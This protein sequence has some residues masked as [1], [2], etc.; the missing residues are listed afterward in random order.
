MSDS[1]H[2]YTRDG[3]AAHTQPTKPGAKNA[4]RATNIK[5]AKTQKLFPSVS[6]IV[7]MKA[8]GGLKRWRDRQI[9]E[10]A[11]HTDRIGTLD[12]WCG[13]VMESAFQQVDDAANLGTKLHAALEAHWTGQPVDFT[14]K[15]VFPST[16]Q[17]VT[18]ETCLRPVIAKE[19]ELGLTP[20]AH[21]AVLVNAEEGYAGTTDQLW[22]KGV[23]MGV[24]DYKTKKTKPGEP[25][26]E[27]DSYKMQLAAY[28]EAKWRNWAYNPNA[29]AYNV[30]ISTTEPGRCDVIEYGQKDLAEAWGAFKACL[31]LWRYENGYDPRTA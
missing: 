16:G 10:A 11:Y 23:L 27:A 26:F 19:T 28:I 24:L 12:E 6:G 17:E 29:R 13:I 18:L 1:S 7:A 20:I 9:C 2:W 15:V 5:D 8:N 3:R 31:T 14:E 4:T 21:E 22:E 25:I 30:Y